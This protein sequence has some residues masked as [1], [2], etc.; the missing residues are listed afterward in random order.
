MNSQQ[1]FGAWDSLQMTYMKFSFVLSL[2]TFD[3]EN[4]KQT[5]QDTPNN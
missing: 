4:E 1:E 2:L 5:I 3:L